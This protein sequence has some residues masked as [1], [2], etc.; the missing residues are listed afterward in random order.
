MTVWLVP[1]N[2]RWGDFFKRTCFAL[3]MPGKF[4]FSPQ[5]GG[6]V[7]MCWFSV[8]FVVFVFNKHEISFFYFHEYLISSV[9]SWSR[10][11]YQIPRFSVPQANLIISNVELNPKTWNVRYIYSYSLICS[12]VN[13]LIVDVYCHE[14]L[15]RF[16]L[17]MD[18]HS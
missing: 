10:I 18:D 5:K 1:R 12:R 6:Q 7:P 3:S 8:E 2:A 13:L 16:Y 17:K 15:I 4:K 9:V 11:S 14:Y